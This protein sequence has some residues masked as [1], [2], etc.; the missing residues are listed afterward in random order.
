MLTNIT[1]DQRVRFIL[2]E[3]RN[4]ILKLVK[5]LQDPM[6]L[7]ILS[8]ING[9]KTWQQIM[10]EMGDITPQAGH[11]HLKQLADL[12]FI[13]REYMYKDFGSNVVC[14][15]VPSISDT[16]ILIRL[17]DKTSKSF[18][19]RFIRIS[20][21]ATAIMLKDAQTIMQFCWALAHYKRLQI[22][23]NLNPET[24]ITEKDLFLKIDLSRKQFAYHMKLLQSSP[25]L[26]YDETKGYRLLQKNVWINFPVK[27]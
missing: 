1:L 20:N 7:K 3:D 18:K 4:E 25:F 21:T 24:W 23:E 26:Q 2:V 19:T 14:E 12:P 27:H 13:H 8:L 22:I 16:N 15:M 9:Q 10:S 11:H 17:V 5:C 6:R